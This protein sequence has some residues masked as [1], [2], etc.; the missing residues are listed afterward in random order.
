MDKDKCKPL[1]IYP[2]QSIQL[3][4]NVKFIDEKNIFR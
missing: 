1:F 4:L 3:Q 2:E